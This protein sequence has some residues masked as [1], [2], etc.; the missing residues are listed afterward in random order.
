MAEH[1]SVGV[2]LIVG[3][4]RAETDLAFFQARQL[5]VVVEGVD[6]EIHRTG[7][8]GVRVTLLDQRFDHGDLF[9]NVRHRA[10]FVVRRQHVQR[11]AVGVEAGGPLG[12]EVGQAAALGLRIADGFVVD[13]GDVAHVVGLQSGDLEGASEHILDD[14]GAEVAD[15]R[16]R[17]DGRSAAVEA[18]A[19]AVERG[20]F[21]N[22][23]G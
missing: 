14:E 17:V 13:V 11:G 22:L 10:G 18:V 19:V 16:G 1:S 4:G 23:S 15:V 9:G 6:L 7:F 8:I 2:G 20:Q 5:A 21:F 3:A 12:R